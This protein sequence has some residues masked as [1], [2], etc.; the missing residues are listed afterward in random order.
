MEHIIQVGNWLFEIKLVKAKKVSAYGE[1]YSGVADIFVHDS[2][3]T[4]ESLK[5]DDFTQSDKCDFEQF[6][7]KCLALK[8]VKFSRYDLNLNRR[9]TTKRL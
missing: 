3:V 7:E 6:I 1:P 5:C 4:I 9:T 2:T 8:T